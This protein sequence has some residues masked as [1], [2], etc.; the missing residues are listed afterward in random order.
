MEW[1]GGYT[2]SPTWCPYSELLLSPLRY[3]EMPKAEKNAISHRFRALRE[4]QEYF[5]GLTSLG[6]SDEHACRGS[7]EG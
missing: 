4:L 5:G 1:G 3:A 7:G 2:P 6:A